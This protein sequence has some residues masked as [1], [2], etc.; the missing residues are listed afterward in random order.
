MARVADHLSVTER[1]NPLGAIEAFRRA[2]PQPTDDG[3]M[4]VVKTMNADQR[5]VERGALDDAA[6]GREIADRKADSCG[7][8]P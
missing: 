4:L 6:L 1:K 2:F 3:P 5:W 8:T 7:E